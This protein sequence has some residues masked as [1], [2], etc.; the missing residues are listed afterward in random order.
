MPVIGAYACTQPCTQICRRIARAMGGDLTATS[1]GLGR[2]TTLTFSIPLCVP[3]ADDA[4]VAAAAKGG[5]NGGGEPVPGIAA[6]AAAAAAGDEST[7]AAPESDDSSGS[8]TAALSPSTPRAQ[9]KHHAAGD[10]SA[11]PPSSPAASPPPWSLATPPPSPSPPASPSTPG[12]PF[13]PGAANVLVAEDD[14]LSQVVMRKLLTA[15]RLRFTLVG[16]GAAAVEAYKQGTQGS[17]CFSEAVRPSFR[18][19]SCTHAL[20]IACHTVARRPQTC[21]TW[22]SWTFTV[23]HFASLA[24]ATIIGLAD[25]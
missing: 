6:A 23:R 19:S 18:H 12:R 21:S 25:E 11:A 4:A 22:C 13:A 8:F 9:H 10:A 2:G 7:P 14:A 20:T 15:L 16:N 5:Q 3:A 17:N 24:A 1:E